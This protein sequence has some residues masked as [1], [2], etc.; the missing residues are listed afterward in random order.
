MGG[1]PGPESRGAVC[2]CCGLRLVFL[3]RLFES[4]LPGQ[5]GRTS[6]MILVVDPQIPT[7]VHWS[8]QEDRASEQFKY[9]RNLESRNPG[10]NW[11]AVRIFSQTGLP[12]VTHRAWPFLA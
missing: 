6:N 8:S 11:K 12:V 10:S 7:G 5:L 4:I 2:G 9:R 3:V 1:D